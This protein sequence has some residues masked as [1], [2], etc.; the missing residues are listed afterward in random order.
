M[1]PEGERQAWIKLL[2]LQKVVESDLSNGD[3]PFLVEFMK[4]Y[5]RWLSQINDLQK[6]TLLLDH[7]LTAQTLAEFTPKL[8][9]YLPDS[10]PTQMGNIADAQQ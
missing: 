9:A 4:T 10:A 1:P 5:D 2:A 8:R 3:K 7:L 6:L